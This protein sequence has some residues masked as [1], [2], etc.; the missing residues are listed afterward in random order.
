[1]SLFQTYISIHIEERPA[2]LGPHS[3]QVM[4]NTFGA[5]PPPKELRNSFEVGAPKT[6]R[7]SDL[8]PEIREMIWKHALPGPRTFEIL[9]YISAAGLKKQLLSRG[10]L[11]MPLAHVCFESRRIV[12]KDGYVLSFQDEDTPGDTGVWFHP[13]ND[14]LEPTI[15]GPGDNIGRE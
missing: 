5:K 12:E 14:V 2:A 4:E 9:V 7:F 15:W 3:K 11:R 13:Q 1:M 10:H 8:P 6:K